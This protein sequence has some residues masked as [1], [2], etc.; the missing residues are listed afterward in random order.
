MTKNALV[1]GLSTL[2]TMAGLLGGPNQA[3]A[4]M[5]PDGQSDP[6]APGDLVYCFTPNPQ[7]CFGN[8]QNSCDY[9]V[10]FF[11]CGTTSV[12]AEGCLGTNYPG[13]EGGEAVEC[14]LIY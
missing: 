14:R 9:A 8:G 4:Q 10:N 13:C 1:I 2:V 12:Q 3:R 7:Y 11:S 5:A 6:C